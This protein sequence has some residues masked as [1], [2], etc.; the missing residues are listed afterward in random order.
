MNRLHMHMHMHVA[1]DNRVD[2]LPGIAWETFH[3]ADTIPVFGEPD[4]KATA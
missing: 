4:K 3:T 2:D 1:V